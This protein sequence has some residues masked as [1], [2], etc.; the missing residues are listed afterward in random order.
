[1][2][3][4][5]T[6]TIIRLQFFFIIHNNYRLVQI[7]CANFFTFHCVS[8]TEIAMASMKKHGEGSYDLMIQKVNDIEFQDFVNPWTF[9]H[10]FVSSNDEIF[11]WLRN[12]GLLAE[13]IT[14]IKCGTPASLKKT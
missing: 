8:G 6:F 14:C 2:S 12:W 9:N 3:N 1:M 11:N 7:I 13:R 5:V 4:I 10:L